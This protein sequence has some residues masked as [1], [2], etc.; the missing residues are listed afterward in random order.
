MVYSFVGA[1]L[2]F[3]VLV[4]TIA[5]DD[6]SIKYVGYLLHARQ[7]NKTETGSFPLQIIM[8]MISIPLGNL[9]IYV[10]IYSASGWRLSHLKRHVKLLM[11]ALLGLYFTAQ[12]QQPVVYGFS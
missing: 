11:A 6:E 9:Y 2:G 4:R 10:F 1:V 3:S 7:E 5:L 12:Q 8:V